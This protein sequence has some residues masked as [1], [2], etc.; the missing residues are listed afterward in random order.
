MKIGSIFEDEEKSEESDE[1]S[2]QKKHTKMSHK[3]KRRQSAPDIFETG[4]PNVKVSRSDK[5]SR[6]RRRENKKRCM[7][8]P[9]DYSKQYWDLFI[10]LILLSSSIITPY[11]IAFG[12]I[13][14]PVQWKII[15]TITDVAFGLDILVIFNS[16]F[17][18][19]EYRIIEDRKK[20]ASVYI[21]SWFLVDILA[22][23]PFDIF[24]DTSQNNYEDFARFMR[25]GRMYRLI[26]MTRMLRI[27]KIVKERV[28]FLTYLNDLLKIGLGFERL[29]FFTLIFFIVAHIL[30][31]FWVISL[32]FTG[33]FTSEDINDPKQIYA[34]SW[35]SSAADL[36]FMQQQVSPYI[37]DGF[38]V[39]QILITSYYFTIQTMAT[40]GYGDLSPKNIDE[41]SLCIV[42][43]LI[44]SISFTFFTGSL[45]S[46]LQNYDN[47]NAKLQERISV[48]NQIY[49]DYSLPLDLYEKLRKS[50]KYDYSKTQNDVTQFVED[51]PHKLKLEISLH[52]YKKTYQK[53]EMFRG[54]SSAF[55][56]WICPLLKPFLSMRNS[57]IF[58][59]GDE[60]NSVYF[61]IKGKAG[62]V[63]PKY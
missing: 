22:I 13:D 11:R 16:A 19:G 2:A 35:L 34:D 6:M 23:I 10:T 39:G 15:N 30:A 52:I 25:F 32:Q 56:A 7:M 49:R 1:G 44:G 29:I 54:R 14:E 28:K 43:M 45:S 48:L 42:I 61:L 37:T 8:Y 38:D 47:A 33:D 51:L 18:D 24:I 46:I 41:R 21:K 9:E 57:Y 12:E 50:V 27:L 62:F 58:F 31:C 17:H 36:P 20:I 60:V 59:E 4:M 55:I 3:H 26:K 5:R 40:V 53:I 63:L